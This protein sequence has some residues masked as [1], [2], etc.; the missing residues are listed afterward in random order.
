[1]S[2]KTPAEVMR[3]FETLVEH[4]I[5]RVETLKRQAERVSYAGLPCIVIGIAGGDGIG[6]V[7][8]DATS[9][10][11]EFLL[12]H[13]IGKG[14]IEL[15]TIE[16]LTIEKRVAC[17]KSVPDGVMKELKKCTVLLKGPT[18]TP[19]EGDPWPNMESANIAIRRELDLFANVRPVRIPPQGIDWTFF[20]ENTEGSYILGSSGINITDD[21]AMDFRVITT[22]GTERIARAAYEYARKNGKTR[23]TI[24]TKAN[25]L[26]ATDGKFLSICKKVGNDFPGISTDDWYVDIL[27]AKLLDEARRGQFQVFILP[28]LYGDII[29]DEAAQIQGGV[30]TAG[31]A[32]IGSSYAMFE[33]IHGSAP[34][35]VT[36][37]R[38]QFANPSSLMR[39]AVL[40]LLHIGYTDHGERLEKAL[41][42]CTITEKEKAVT[43]NSNGVTAMEFADYVIET[44]TKTFSPV[45]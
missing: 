33:A 22:P 28:N 35:M 37:G 44:V 17:G 42:I 40:M 30:G 38:A 9:R 7:I 26:K 4:E 25:V 12:A 41:D 32:N 43:G 1:M 34:R 6:P 29:T 21:I 15:R 36:E 10:V 8:S 11:L 24:V 45:N 16:G 13:E 18:T 19:R 3:Q 39:A 5:L 20:R 14:T 27:A 23:V 2:E 31:S